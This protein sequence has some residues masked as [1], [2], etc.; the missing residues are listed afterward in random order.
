V[1]KVRATASQNARSADLAANRALRGDDGAGDEPGCGAEKMAGWTVTTPCH[2]RPRREARPAACMG[3][4]PARRSYF[5]WR[6]CATAGRRGTV[7]VGG[8]RVLPG[9]EARDDAV[10]LLARRSSR[11]HD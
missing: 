9:G 6:L 2:A 3:A 5:E 7:E 8:G 4:Q 1:T 10:S 11:S